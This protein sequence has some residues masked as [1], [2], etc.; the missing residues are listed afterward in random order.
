MFQTLL[1][2]ILMQIPVFMVMLAVVYWRRNAKVSLLG[3]TA[4][5]LYFVIRAGSTLQ[6]ALIPFLVDG[7]G[8]LTQQT[9]GLTACLNVAWYALSA[10]P[11]GCC[12]GRPLGGARRAMP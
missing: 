1:L 6:N 2:T 8:L 12:W 3:L 5:A 10:I 4:M 11:W 9:V 7:Q